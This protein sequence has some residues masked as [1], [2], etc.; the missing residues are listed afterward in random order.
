MNKIKT[1]FHAP[2]G[3][4][5]EGTAARDL[6][7]TVEMARFDVASRAA[8]AGSLRIRFSL[9][10]RGSLR[11]R[12]PLPGETRLVGVVLFLSKR[13]TNI[14]TSTATIAITTIITTSITSTTTNSFHFDAECSEW[15]C[16]DDLHHYFF[17]YMALIAA[18]GDAPAAPCA[19][20]SVSG[21]QD[22]EGTATS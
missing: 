14:N 1:L 9:E 7:S 5:A 22:A 6:L 12:L 20:A 13:A 17:S 8:G 10:K 3:F 18:S 11:Q 2:S 4:S 16:L 21:G 19:G 15:P